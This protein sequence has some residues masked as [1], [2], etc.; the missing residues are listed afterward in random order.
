VLLHKLQ[1]RQPCLVALV[2]CHSH[3]DLATSHICPLSI[4]P[5]LVGLAGSC[6]L[7]VEGAQ[8]VF[9]QVAPSNLLC[10]FPVVCSA[11]AAGEGAAAAVTARA[12]EATAVG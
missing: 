7:A 6:T 8:L 2:H 1:H 9:R 3:I 11:A 12:M 10:S 4:S 5:L